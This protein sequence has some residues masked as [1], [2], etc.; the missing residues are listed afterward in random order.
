MIRSHGQHWVFDQELKVRV[1]GISQRHG[2]LAVYKALSNYGY[3]VR[4]EVVATGHDSTAYVIFRPPPASRAW[5]DRV[6]IE[7]AQVKVDVLTRFSTIPSPVNPH[8]SYPEVNVLTANSIDFGVRMAEFNMRK[9]YTSTMPKKIQLALDLRRKR[10]VVTFPAQID[11]SLRRYQFEMPIAL[12]QHV[13]R[14]NDSQA[15]QC[16]LFIPF[17]CPP[18]FFE[19]VRKE[20]ESF[21]TFSPSIRFWNEDDAFYRRTDV[22]S[23][24]MEDHLKSNPVMNMKDSSIIDIGRWTTYRFSFHSSTL[25]SV[26]YKDFVDALSDHGIAVHDR[27]EYQVLEKETAPLW[28]LLEDEVSGTHPHFTP[29]SSQAASGG[30]FTDQFHLDFSVRYQLEACLSHGYLKEHTIVR[31]FLD[32]LSA[33]NPAEAAFVLEKIMDKKIT[34]FNPMKVFNVRIDG[35]RLSKKIPSHCVLARS[36]NIT[37]TMMHVV[38]PSVEISNRIIRQ[39][40]ADGD[41]FIRVKFTD[42][43]TEGRLGNQGKKSDATFEKVRRALEHGIVVAGRYYEFLATGNSQFRENGA[44]FYAPTNLQTADDIRR[45]LGMFDHIRT[46]AKFGARIGQCF[47]TTRAIQIRIQYV[48]I[49]DIERNGFTFTDGVGKISRFL[50]Q[51]AAQEL[52]I[53]NAFEDPP[54]LFQFRL[55]GCKGVVAVDPKVQHREVHIRPSQKKFQGP[56]EEVLEII[57]ASSFATAYFNRQLI[58]VLSTLDVSDTVF[59]RKQQEMVNYLEKAMTDEV[60]ALERLQRNVDMNQ[61]SLTMAGMVLDGFM[62]SREPFLMSLLQLWRAY[63]IKCLK[64]KARIFIE[65]GAFLLGCIDETA[66]LRGHLDHHQSRPDA[67]REGKLAT[68]PEIFLQIS[69]PDKK[70]AYN[71]IEGVCI[72][73]RN[74]SLHPGDLRIVRAVNVPALSHLKNVVVLPQTGDRD[75][76]NMCSGGDLDGD[77]YLVMWDQDFLPTTINEPPMDFTP[78]TPVEQDRPIT[79]ADIADFFVTYMKNDSLGKIA[80]A[81][82]A[83]ADYNEDGVRNDKC[84]ELAQLHSLAV[85]FP[86]SGI[87]AVMTSELKPRKWPHFMEKKHLEPSKIYHSKN[88]LGMLYDQVKLVDFVPQT[89]HHFDSRIL[90]AFE[91]DDRVLQ[92]AASI[93]S[94]YDETIKRLMAKHG[95]QTEFEVWSIFVLTHN[96]ESR[97]YKFAEEFGQTMDAIKDKFRQACREAAGVSSAL[98]FGKLAP[99]VAAMYTVTAREMEAAIK[100]CQ[101]TKTVGGKLV[102]KRDPGDMPLI[103]FPWLFVG[104]LGRIAKDRENANQDTS[105]QSNLNSLATFPSMDPFE[106]RPTSVGEDS[107]RKATP[108]NDTKTKEHARFEPDPK[109]GSPP[110]KLQMNEDYPTLAAAHP[111][112]DIIDRLESAS[113]SIR[114]GNDKKELTQDTQQKED[115]ED[116]EIE[117]VERKKNQGSALDR[118]KKFM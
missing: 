19:R 32:R 114:N 72:L 18:R 81:H 9:M 80:H 12:L 74:P 14:V 97:D 25:K 16:C 85:D 62:E 96:Q 99:F 47:S 13:Y 87:P 4:I 110:G 48:E 76:A 33:M 15:G 75:L 64:E 56:K 58:I 10:I 27:S 106:G 101:E 112:H 44:Y 35:H 79:V 60:V 40:G 53:Q 103:S 36:V 50:A 63:N 21:A 98:N 37:P 49:A 117:I 43:K 17:D 67:T 52:G 105:C 55:A 100:E 91:L 51:L 54:S 41:R 68:L 65:K 46:I 109:G 39:Y 70:G 23:R 86:K 102:P 42:E 22:T 118:L 90:S 1:S 24:E 73:A 69:D 89:R 104:E 78:P 66:T 30:L 84:L 113:L 94:N 29:V 8:R 6:R 26:Q 107:I 108:T 5:L 83:Q 82:L 71:L 7:G 111:M 57:R 77:D 31:P 34:I 38:T 92:A 95:I 11:G 28:D 88:V 45:S 59:I 93:K 115:E 3:I 20:Q 2:T 116:Y 61:T